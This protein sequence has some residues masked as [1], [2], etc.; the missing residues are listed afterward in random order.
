MQNSL[1][2]NYKKKRHPFITTH[3]AAKN[4]G[5][6]ATFNGAKILHK[7]KLFDYYTSKVYFELFAE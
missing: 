1:G 6:D 4:C 5:V 3:Q 7:F 2:Q